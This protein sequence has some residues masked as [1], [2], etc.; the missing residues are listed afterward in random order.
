MPLAKP[1]YATL[2]DMQA[3]YEAS[4]LLQLT[5][6]AD[7]GVIDADTVDKAI[8]DASAIITGYVA[9]RHDNIELI[10][11]NPILNMICCQIAYRKL[12]RDTPPDSIQKAHD[13]A[14]A[15]LGKISKGIVVLDEGREIAPARSDAIHTDSATKRMSRDSLG[16]F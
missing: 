3:R 7:A 12:W 10:A 6:Q 5:D 11:D 15:E 2:A 13:E 9:R 8:A 4:D 16:G 14:I 1:Q